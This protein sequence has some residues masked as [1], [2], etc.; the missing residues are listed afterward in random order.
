MEAIAVVVGVI[1]FVWAL[2]LAFR[3]V[4]AWIGCL[5]ILVVFGF[6]LFLLPGGYAASGAILGGVVGGLAG[7]IWRRTPWGR[8]ETPPAPEV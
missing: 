8:P 1:L 4:A 3:G 7:Y 5:P 2:V 6:S